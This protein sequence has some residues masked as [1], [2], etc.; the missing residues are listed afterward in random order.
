MK[1]LSKVERA[2]L[3]KD[4]LDDAIEGIEEGWFVPIGGQY[5]DSDLEEASAQ[6]RRLSVDDLIRQFDGCEG[7]AMGVMLYA[8]A[9][10]TSN[11]N[12]SGLGSGYDICHALEPVFTGEELRNLEAAFE[13]Y[14]EGRWGIFS[15]VVGKQTG[16]SKQ[17]DKARLLKLLHHWR[18][19]EEAA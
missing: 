11:I 8:T 15:G 10:A 1:R 13:D 19:V 14:D 4:A 3:R 18:Q 17:V 5:T 9:Y 2:Q 6:N 16:W 7:C 12:S